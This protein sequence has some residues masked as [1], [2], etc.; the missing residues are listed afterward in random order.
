MKSSKFDP[1]IKRTNVRNINF[2]FTL[3]NKAFII[4]QFVYPK[5]VTNFVREKFFTPVTKPL[6][7]PQKS[8][9]KRAFLH[10]IECRGKEL[11]VWKIGDGP[12]IL[13]VHGWNGRGAQF[14]RFFQ[15]LLDAGYSVIF[16]DAPAHGLSGGE[17][18]NYLEIT[19]SIE[20]IFDHEIGKDITGVIAHSLGTSALIN[21]LSRHHTDIPIALI[22]PAL[23]LMEL[24]FTNF[25]L[26]GIPKK[27][28]LKLLAEVENTFQIPLETQNPIDLIYTIKN[29]VLIIHD[30]DDK[31]TP[32]GPSIQVANDL[33]NVEL[34]ETKGLGHSHLLKNKIVVDSV[35]NFL[36]EQA[37]QKQAA[38][39]GRKRLKRAKDMSFHLTSPG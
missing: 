35:V 26:H 34:V 24:L 38:G 27:T 14:Q 19:E 11:S 32:I 17:M 2:A 23:Y 6:T 1:F 8:W 3:L 37:L 16:Y 15:P 5:A 10:K 12:S 36:K 33:D 21:Q 28:Y 25:Q 4:G 30:R 18:T 31:T 20:K 9:I 7:K 29:E 39:I 22:A 13:F